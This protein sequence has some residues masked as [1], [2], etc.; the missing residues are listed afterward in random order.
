[1]TRAER[2]VD[3]L[4]ERPELL[5]EVVRLLRER[6]NKVPL[7]RAIVIAE[8]VHAFGQKHGLRRDWHEPDEQDIEAT[9]FGTQLDNA[10]GNTIRAQ[11]IDG[12]YQEFVVE[13]AHRPGDRE[14]TDD[15]LRVNVADLLAIA[16]EFW[17]LTR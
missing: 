16:S 10:S 4:E 2:I 5:D 13:V 9:I 6:A 15:A 8:S 3:A 12:G 14:A 7:Q 11:A 1:M 17:S